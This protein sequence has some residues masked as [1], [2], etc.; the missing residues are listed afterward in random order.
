[1]KQVRNFLFWC[2][3]LTGTIV[4]LFILFM[5]VTGA[6]IAFEDQIVNFA[7]R[8]VNT[9]RVPTQT[10]RLSPQTLMAKL[11]EARPNIK[12]SG[13]VFAS[14]PSSAVIVNLGRDGVL[15]IDPYTGTLLGESSQ[16]VRKFFQFVTELHRWL[17]LQGGNRDVG[18]LITGFTCICFLFMA[19]SGLYLWCPRGWTVQQLK[20][21]LL[22][23]LKLKG[24]A[25]NFNLHNVIGF[26]SSLLLISITITGT[27]MAFQWAENFLYTITGSEQPKRTSDNKPRATNLENIKNSSNA[28]E[29]KEQQSVDVISNLDKFYNQAEKQVPNWQ[30]I[31][32][33]LPTNSKMPVSFSI[34]QGNY[35]QRSQLNLDQSTAEIISWEPY[36]SLN[37]GRK[38]RSWTKPLHTGEA[39]GLVGQ[40]IIWLTAISGI[41]LVWTGLALTLHRFKTWSAK[42]KTKN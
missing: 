21:V 15:F 26:W 29:S 36:S 9:V 17:A 40:I 13:L 1:V 31:N 39:L 4:G 7:E 30:T 20:A 8:K 18:K 28:A 11:K 35:W 37:S 2:H 19:L 14:N 27:I 10:Q 23:R 12:P 33:R 6:L 24:H 3:L 22:L 5:L 38:L 34:D 25:R 41:F 42:H 32:L 16:Q